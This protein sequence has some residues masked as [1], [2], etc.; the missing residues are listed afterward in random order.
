MKLLFASFFLFL[1]SIILTGCVRF[2]SLRKAI[3]DIPNERSSHFTPTP[4]GGGTAIVSTFFIGILGLLWQGL[5]AS[6]LAIALL[7]GG[8]IVAAIGYRDDLKP[9]PARWRAL[10]HLLAASWAVYWLGGFPQLNLG[11][12]EIH[13]GW[14]GSILA[15]F[16]IIWLINLYNFMDGIDG[17]AGSEAAFVSLISG[18]ALLLLGQIGLAA[19]CFFLLAASLGFLSWNWPPA[20]IFLGDVGSGFLGFIFGVLIIVTAKQPLLPLLFWLTLLSCFIFDATFTLL[21]RLYR[22]QAF[23]LAHRDHIYQRLLQQGWSHKKVTLSLLLINLIILLPIAYLILIL[24]KWSLL[25]FILLSISFGSAWFL[26]IKKI[27]A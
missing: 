26:L 18:V 20:K 3:L 19:L 22:K 1:L 16:G 11:Y 5:I 9:V 12:G 24:P 17:I 21:H 27:R 8:F 14:L 15:V 10:S 25:F 13:L 7:G 23:Y 2:Y 6:N 4:R